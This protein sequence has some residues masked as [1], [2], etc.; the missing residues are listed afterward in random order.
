MAIFAMMH[1][2]RALFHMKWSEVDNQ[3]FV[4]VFNNSCEYRE[5]ILK[6]VEIKSILNQISNDKQL[7]QRWNNYRKKNPYASTIEFKE[8]LK[9]LEKVFEPIIKEK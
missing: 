4:K 2:M 9:S 8:V 1:N 5:T 7:Y 3:L 6:N